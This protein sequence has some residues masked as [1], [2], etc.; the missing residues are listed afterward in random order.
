MPPLATAGLKK[1]PT[2]GKPKS[3]T[4]SKKAPVAAKTK[5]AAGKKPAAQKP[6]RTVKVPTIVLESVIDT[7]PAVLKAK[8]RPAG[9]ATVSSN[10]RKRVGKPEAKKPNKKM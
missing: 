8:A 5:K 7:P 2:P 4:A 1:T 3:R 6:T 10:K 9:R